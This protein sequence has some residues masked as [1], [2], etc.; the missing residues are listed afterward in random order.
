MKT[1]SAS[2]MAVV[3]KMQ[4]NECNE[5]AI[6]EK[7]AK[8]AKG[9]VNK[10]TLLRLAREEHAHNKIWEKYTGIGKICQRM[11]FVLNCN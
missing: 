9:D 5:S 8:F 2:A 1:I 11:W 7:I 3:K 10:Q 4:Q 6:Y